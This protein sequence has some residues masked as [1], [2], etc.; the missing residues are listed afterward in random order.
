MADFLD[1]ADQLRLT[2]RSPAVET[3]EEALRLMDRYPWHKLYTVTLHKEYVG[4]VRTEKDKRLSLEPRRVRL[5][6]GQLTR[7]AALSIE[8]SLRE[9]G[10]DIYYDHG[11]IKNTFMGKIVSSLKEEYRRGEELA[12]LD[13]TVVKRGTKEVVALIEIE[14]T[15]DKPK[16]LLGDVFGTLMGNF[17]SVPVVGSVKVGKHTSLIII[18]RGENHKDRNRHIVEKTMVIKSTLGTGNSELGNIVIKSFANAEELGSV[19]RDAIEEAIQR[20]V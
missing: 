5:S 16:T 15:N 3:F 11:G 13:I 8:K 20:S 4:I 7:E 10:Y 17:I 9:R 2:E 14:E 18:A 6:P 12:Q 19:T 1:E